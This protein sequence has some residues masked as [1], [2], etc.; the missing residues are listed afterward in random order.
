MGREGKGRKEKDW[1]GTGMHGRTTDQAVCVRHVELH[2]TAREIRLAV[3]RPG[4]LERFDR[5]TRVM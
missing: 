1:E 3:L 5:L 2:E 4:E